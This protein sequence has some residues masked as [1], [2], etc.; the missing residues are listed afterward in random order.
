METGVANHETLMIGKDRLI[1]SGSGEQV[2]IDAAHEMPNW[3]VREFLR[4]PI[5][6][7]EHKFFLRQRIQGH[8]PYAMRYVLERWPEDAYFDAAPVSFIYDEQYVK[9][10]D[11]EQAYY[12][13]MD[14]LAKVLLCL[15]P[16]LGF[17]WAG[18]KKKLI[19]AGFVPRTITGISIF[20]GVCL[21]LLQGTF[22]RMNLG[23]FTMVFGNI[24]RIEFGLL[25]CDYAL[26]G[27]MLVDIV[28]RFDQHLKHSEN[29]WGFGEWITK[30]FRRRP[31]EQEEQ[32]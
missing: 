30:P 19:P 21:L 12:D 31:T 9:E 17:L 23:L 13:R 27:L 24:K 20:T 28:L 32:L 15:Y 4:M 8:P 25:M 14:K 3:Q 5:Y 29:P 11:A 1:I 6:V 26:F 2:M 22:L 10:R 18:T 7:G 16:L